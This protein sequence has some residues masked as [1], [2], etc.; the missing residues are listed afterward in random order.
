MS[1]V[2]GPA[3]RDS[4]RSRRPFSG[5]QPHSLA[6][7]ARSWKQQSERTALGANPGLAARR[8]APTSAVRGA[9]GRPRGGLDFLLRAME[10]HCGLK[11]WE[12]PGLGDF[13]GS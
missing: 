12:F 5:S 10:S 11:V 8:R 7:G 13:S 1:H 2:R 9:E 6:L 3:A 4:D